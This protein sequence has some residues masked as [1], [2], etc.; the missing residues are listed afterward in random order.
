[1]TSRPL[2][3]TRPPA[4][5]RATIYQRERFPLAAF[6]PLA[7]A[8]A[9]AATC[10]GQL[11]RGVVTWPGA[12]DVLAAT[13]SALAFFLQMRVADEFKD[14]DDDARWRAY[15]PVPRGLVGLH[16]LAGVA[17]AAAV[18]Q[19]LIALGAGASA[20]AALIAA[21]AYLGLSAVEFGIGVW[22]KA[23]PAIY[24]ASHL[25]I[26]G[27]I[28]VQLA[29]FVGHGAALSELS[30]LAPL[31]ATACAGAFVLEIGRKLRLPADEE[32]GVVTYTAAWGLR[33]AV[34]AWTFAMALLAASAMAA[35]QQVGALALPAAAMLAVL[36]VGVAFAHRA[37]AAP[38]AARLARLDA[39]GRGATLLAYLGVG[40]LALACRL[41]AVG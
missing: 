16:E 13:L 4:W 34:A 40:P 30:A 33:P 29:G 11:L 8:S 14:R 32:A 35:A 22:L 28:M 10:H 41:G 37:F 23:R 17:L 19:L 27:L 21:W 20:S 15:R 26:A 18:I 5:L 9:I 36:S 39:F 1:M 12:S 25:P 38:G 24:L 31:F 7:A 3:G 2:A 6:V